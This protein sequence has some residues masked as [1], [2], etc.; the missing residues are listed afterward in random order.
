[1]YVYVWIFSGFFPDKMVSE[2]KSRLVVS[3]SLRP[4]GL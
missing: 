2:V 3:D 1:M 4:H